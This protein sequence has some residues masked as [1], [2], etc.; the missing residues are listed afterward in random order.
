[1]SVGLLLLAAAGLLPEGT[2]GNIA[3]VFG[4]FALFNLLINMGPNAT[5]FILPA[6]LFPTD[7]RG[8]AHGLAAAAGKV[9]AAVGVFLLPVLKETLGLSTTLLTVAAA[10]LLGLAVTW[11]LGVETRGKSLEG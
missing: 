3:L 10:S 8:S 5:T 6:E 4:G 7:L 1:M 11:L 9:G 2:M